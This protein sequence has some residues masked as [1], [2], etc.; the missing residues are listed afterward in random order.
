[1]GRTLGL[2]RAG[3]IRTP[4]E[5]LSPERVWPRKGHRCGEK[6][7]AAAPWVRDHLRAVPSVLPPS[8]SCSTWLLWELGEKQ[9]LD[10]KAFDT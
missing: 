8:T 3:I 9:S 6:N 10:C 1:M 7:P 4:Q 2:R 5:N